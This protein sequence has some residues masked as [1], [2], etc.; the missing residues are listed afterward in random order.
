MQLDQKERHIVE[1]NAQLI[2]LEQESE[3]LKMD[4]N[5]QSLHMSLMQQ[6][7][8]LIQNSVPIERL[9]QRRKT[10][11]CIMTPRRNL[12]AELTSQIQRGQDTILEHSVKSQKLIQKR[13]RK[14]EED[15]DEDGN[16]SNFWKSKAEQLL[17]QVEQLEEKIA[18][19]QY[20][21]RQMESNLAR[22]FALQDKY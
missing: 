7:I 16:Q 19:M 12:C 22:F 4:E 14:V 8:G 13:E 21:E 5:K 15:S 17:K 20:S 18:L 11:A 3:K 2:D 9:A 6:G 10:I 1:L